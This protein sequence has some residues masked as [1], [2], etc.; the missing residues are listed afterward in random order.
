MISWI[1]RVLEN[2]ISCRFFV[3]NLLGGFWDG[4][5]F[6]GLNRLQECFLDIAVFFWIGFDFLDL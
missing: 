1:R 5:G 6:L 4:F 3:D 2:I